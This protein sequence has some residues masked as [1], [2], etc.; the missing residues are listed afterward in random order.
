MKNLTKY[1]MSRPQH[2]PN[3]ILNPPQNN[4]NNGNLQQEIQTLHLFR[5]KVSQ[6]NSYRIS[7]QNSLI[8]MGKILLQSLLMLLLRGYG[9]FFSL[10]VWYL[11]IAYSQLIYYPLSNLKV[12][13]IT[14][15]SLLL[16]LLVL[17]L[18]TTSLLII[19]IFHHFPNK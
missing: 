14:L 3:V 15:I 13:L 19:K 7:K 4:R 12:Y 8:K 6:L 11:K 9:V 1:L 18:L 16:L 17:L 2:L 10:L 5:Q